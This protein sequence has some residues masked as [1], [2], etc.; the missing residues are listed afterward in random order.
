MSLESPKD[1][2]YSRCLGVMKPE[3]IVKIPEDKTL[4]LL[5]KEQF[6]DIVG[7]STMTEL[8]KRE[9]ETEKKEWKFSKKYVHI[10]EW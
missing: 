2:D 10:L 7:E 4:N 3:N 1:T 5:T 9:D 8:L 6:I